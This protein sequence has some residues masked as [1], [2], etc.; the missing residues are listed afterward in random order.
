M[1]KFVISL[2]NDYVLTFFGRYPSVADT[3]FTIHGYRPKMLNNRI[4]D[5]KVHPQFVCHKAQ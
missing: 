2:W 5:F 3:V 1:L 4:R